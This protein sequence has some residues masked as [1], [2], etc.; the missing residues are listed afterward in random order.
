MED[1]NLQLG[2]RKL[3]VLGIPWEIN[4]DGLKQYMSKYG[5]LDDVVVMKDR[6]TGRSRG[7]GYVTFTTAESAE[8]ALEA[9]HTINGRELEVKVATPKEEMKNPPK[10]ITRIFVARIPGKVSEDEFKKYFEK[11]G[12]ITD[13]YMPS[14]SGSKSHR[15]IGF[16]TFE[17]PD[18]VAKIMS[19]TH[20]LGGSA[21][22]VDEATPKDEGGDRSSSRND[23]YGKKNHEGSYLS[24]YYYRD[25][26]GAYGAYSPYVAAA[27]AGSQRYGGYGGLS[28]YGAYDYSGSYG[29][30]YGSSRYGGS[31]FSSMPP[32]SGGYSGSAV[33]TP[34]SRASGYGSGFG[35][36]RNRIFVG[37]LPSEATSE[38]LRHYFGNFGRIVDVFL[39]KDIKGGGHRGFAFVTFM[40]EGPADRV[41]RRAHEL[42]GQEIAVEHASPQDD[43]GAGDTFSGSAGL[44][45]SSA[46][47][48]YVGSGYRAPM[49][50]YSGYGNSGSYGSG[51]GP[52]Y[53]ADRGSRSEF[54]YRPY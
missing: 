21:I 51:I 54:R 49:D 9:K 28:S 40:D 41:C 48:A 25:Y 27:G 50:Y 19:E 2:N 15:G 38:D 23:S 47:S 7:F 42:L 1:T 35:R 10:K 31:G 36:P 30:D 4:T 22:V 3:V 29:S 24:K 26:A 44:Y 39:P 16:I 12:T 37:R 8:K 43:S 45:G 11:Y 13:I 52:M 14:E 46:S 6:R 34:R 18:S 20:E 33:D 53:D 5:N 32:S 17:S